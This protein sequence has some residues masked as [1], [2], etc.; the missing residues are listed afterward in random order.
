M[1]RSTP[2]RMWV[3]ASPEPRKRW[4]FWAR[5]S[6]VVASSRTRVASDAAKRGESTFASVSATDYLNGIVLGR[7]ARGI[8]RSDERHEDRCD[9]RG[10]VIARVLAHEQTFRFHKTFHLDR[11]APQ[12][13][14]RELS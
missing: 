2:L 5:R 8:D 13:F 12:E 9:E 4:T 7:A 11:D 6:G 10:D 1:V 3:R 14:H